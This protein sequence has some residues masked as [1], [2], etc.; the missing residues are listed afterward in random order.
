MG[1]RNL[2]AYLRL[3][4]RAAK[5][6]EIAEGD[7]L[8]LFAGAHNYPGTFTNG[9]IRTSDAVAA[10][11]VIDR[12]RSFFS[13][14]RRGFVVWAR[15]HADTDL[16][17]AARAIGL[18]PRPPAE[19]NA[20]IAIDRPP[21][22]GW[23]MHGLVLRQV[24]DDRGGREYLKIVAAGWGLAGAPSEVVEA[25]L[26]NPDS[27]DSP[28]VAVFLAYADGMPV[29]G[30]MVFVAEQVAGLYWAATLP[31]ARGKGFAK[32]CFNAAWDAGFSMGATCAWG[33]ASEVGTPIWLRLG[34]EVVTRYRRY[35]VR[36]PLA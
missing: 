26:F 22:D 9:V 13:P 14:R 15:G 16:D 33:M 21:T 24:D 34:F 31:D 11:E 8:L 35:L 4:T 2:V 27:L 6:G 3:V 36:P 32:A 5:G 20:G 29:A 17:E 23:R 25:V 7:G 1:D 19:G 10:P 12:A 18:W 30:C 28:D